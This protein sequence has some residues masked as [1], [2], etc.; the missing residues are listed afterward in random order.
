M[1]NDYKYNNK[2]YIDDLNLNM[3]DYGARLLDPLTGRWNGVDALAERYHSSSGYGYVAGNLINTI[4][5]K[6]FR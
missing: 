2:E 6:R 3:L 4:D 5:I 1:P